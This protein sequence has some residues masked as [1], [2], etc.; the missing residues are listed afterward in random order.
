MSYVSNN[1]LGDVSKNIKSE[2]DGVVVTLNPMTNNIPYTVC[3]RWATTD[4]TPKA[5]RPNVAGR[6]TYSWWELSLRS[7]V[8]M[9]DSI[10]GAVN[11]VVLSGR[12]KFSDWIFGEESRV[13]SRS[14]FRTEAPAS[15]A[16]RPDCRVRAKLLAFTVST[17]IWDERLS[18][19]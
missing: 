11:T 15:A 1:K 4:V 10:R 5:S 6:L 8:Q 19:L 7:E 13:E 2:F 14:G 18:S 9:L 16:F 12:E 3:V 17:S